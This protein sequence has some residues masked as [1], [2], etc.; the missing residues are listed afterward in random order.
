MTSDVNTSTILLLVSFHALTTPYHSILT[1][2]V[3]LNYMNFVAAMN[4]MFTGPLIVPE[5]ALSVLPFFLLAHIYICCEDAFWNNYISSKIFI[6]FD[7][8]I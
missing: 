3:F 1:R 7:L 2:V 5:F 8:I 4:Y 6:N